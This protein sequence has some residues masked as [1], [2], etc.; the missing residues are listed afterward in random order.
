MKKLMVVI[1]AVL[2][3]SGAA[4]AAGG[5]LIFNLYGNRLDMAANKFTGQK[6]MNRTYFEAKAACAVSGNIYLWAS[7][8][9]F[10]V[11][12]SWKS[13]EKKG[14]FAPDILTDRTLAKRVISGGA[15]LYI[16]YFEPGQLGVRVEAGLCHIGNAID[17]S[18]S[19]IASGRHL[20]TATAS[21][22]GIGARGNLSFTYGLY[23]SV[24][25][26]LAAG[27][28]YAA[29][30]IDEVRSKLGG[31]QVALGLGIQL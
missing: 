28:L 29:D 19:D 25:A 10:P 14:S 27:Y 7:H 5:R 11:R 26:E 6:S 23:K 31:F 4:S 13:W 9:Y 15:G 8:G 1:S 24:F 17:S 18:V 16:G 3:F 2:L 22:R 20:R 30:K 21:Q 12:D